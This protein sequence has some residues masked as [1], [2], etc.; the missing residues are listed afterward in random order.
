MAKIALTFFSTPSPEGLALRDEFIEIA[1]R[2]FH[3]TTQTKIGATQVEFAKACMN[4]DLVVFDAT[5]EA[6]GRHNYFAATLQSGVL[7]HVLVVSRTYLPIN[8]YCFRQG[9]APDYPNPYTGSS[10]TF[11]NADIITWLRKQI[12]DLRPSLPRRWYQKGVGSVFAMRTSTHTQSEQN[13]QV[14]VSYRSSDLVN[15]DVSSNEQDT[16]SDDL[17]YKNVK[18]V[19]E[20]LTQMQKVAF[21]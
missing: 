17:E 6:D 13:T 1:E 4:D 20:K 9:G 21:E 19:T 18:A 7:D 12:E 14:F 5:I 10:G 11:T 3:F 8:L 15:R 16:D 2:E